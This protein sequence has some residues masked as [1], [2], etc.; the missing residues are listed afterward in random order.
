M[1]KDLLKVANKL[2]AL[3]LSKEADTVDTLIQKIASKYNTTMIDFYHEPSKPIIP[4]KSRVPSDEVAMDKL[5]ERAKMTV[6][7]MNELKYSDMEDVGEQRGIYMDSFY[8]AAEDLGFTMEIA[9]QVYEDE[10]DRVE[11]RRRSRSRY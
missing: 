2:D 11:N 7:L 5:K 3:G 8:Q 6:A 9:D 4:L 1:L 10:E